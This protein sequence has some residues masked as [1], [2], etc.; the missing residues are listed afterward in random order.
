[1]ESA[2]NVKASKT[3]IVLDTNILLAIERFKIDIFLEAKKMMGNVEF[4]IPQQV[5]EELEMLEK[6]G[7]KLK[8]AVRIAKQLIDK[9]N[10]KVISVDADNADKA[11]LEL[12]KNAIVA[13]N[14]KEL[15]DS[16]K[17]INGQ[18]LFLR[19][20]KFLELN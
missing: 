6:R 19:Q 8:K 3:K 2:N 10:V 20:K 13:T 17:Q 12:S 7:L 15:K 4:W 1:M 9:N 16:V 14:D 18:V 11:L 5:V